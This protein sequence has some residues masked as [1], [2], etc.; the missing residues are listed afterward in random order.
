MQYVANCNHLIDLH[1]PFELYIGTFYGEAYF[2]MKASQY[3][4]RTVVP[5]TANF[6]LEISHPLFNCPHHKQQH[7]MLGR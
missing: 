7:E 3:S 1:R 4:S 5:T 2:P 6:V